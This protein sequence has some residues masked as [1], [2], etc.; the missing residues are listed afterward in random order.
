[1]KIGSWHYS[2]TGAGRPLV[3]LHGLGMSHFA[4]N[5]VIP[6]LSPTRRVIAFDTAG[7]GLTPSLPEGTVP[8]V[9]NL[10]NGLERSLKEIGVHLPVDMAGNS[11]GGYMALEAA[12]RRMASS[13]VAIC[14]AG[15]WKQHPAHHVRYLFRAMRFLATR[16]PGLL[17]AVVRVPALR[18]LA[19]AVPVSVGSSRMA[20]DDAVRAVDDLSN[21]QAFEATFAASSSPFAGPEIAVPVTVAFGDRDGIVTKSSRSRHRLPAHTRWVTIHGWGHVPM[22]VDPIGVAR[23][24][25]DGTGNG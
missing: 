4:W 12:R 20:A 1:M 14:P 25:L 22:W 5:A 6:Y 21:S 23:L 17:K 18:E 11:L 2:E 10:V 19:F 15:L 3:L 9:P 24:I 8:T 16:F 13:V 7:F